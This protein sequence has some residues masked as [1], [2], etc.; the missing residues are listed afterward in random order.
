MN[1]TKSSKKT[2]SHYAVFDSQNGSAALTVR[3]T[4]KFVKGKMKLLKS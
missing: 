1:K 3:D 2:T 4:T